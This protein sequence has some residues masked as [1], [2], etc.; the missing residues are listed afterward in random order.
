MLRQTIIRP[1]IQANQA[2][3]TRS[4]SVAAPRFGEGDTGAPRA[5][6]TAAG[7]VLSPLPRSL[8]QQLCYRQL[9]LCSA[10]SNG[11]CAAPVCLAA[12]V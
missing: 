1:V 9:C 7:F 4:F 2:L 10:A 6:G 3:M 11:H 12:A 8:H 5:G